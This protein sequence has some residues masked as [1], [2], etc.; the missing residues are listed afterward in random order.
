MNRLAVI[1]FME[2]AS[3]EKQHRL[4]VIITFST[5]FVDGFHELF[6]ISSN[7]DN[8]VSDTV[9]GLVACFGTS[10]MNSSGFVMIFSLI[11]TALFTF[12]IGMATFFFSLTQQFSFDDNIDVSIRFRL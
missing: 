8:F 1:G 3:L 6:K 12:L 4:R 7:N 11:L 10:T 2:M 5:D 9:S